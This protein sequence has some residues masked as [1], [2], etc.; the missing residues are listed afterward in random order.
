MS[1]A[2]IKEELRRLTPDERLEIVREIAALEQAAMDRMP[3]A[4][5]L[6]AAEDAV[7]TKHRALLQRLAK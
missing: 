6:A 2:E 5:A 7:F 1:L 3:K 4:E